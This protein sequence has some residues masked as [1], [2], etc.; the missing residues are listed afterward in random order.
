MSANSSYDLD[1]PYHETEIVFTA[2]SGY[3]QTSAEPEVSTAESLTPLR[4]DDIAAQQQVELL[5]E[6]LETNTVKRAATPL[7]AKLVRIKQLL[8]ETRQLN[9]ESEKYNTQAAVLLSA[10]GSLKAEL[11]SSEAERDTAFS[12]LINIKKLSEELNLQLAQHAASAEAQNK[13]SADNNSHSETLI[14]NLD[15]LVERAKIQQSDVN[16]KLDFFTEQAA[17][18]QNQA[19]EIDTK[20]IEISGL[21]SEASDLLS[22]LNLTNDSAQA[23]TNEL[24]GL[25]GEFRSAK[26]ECETLRDSLRE[27]KLEVFEERQA[28]QVLNAQSKSQMQQSEKL[29]GQQI[30]LLDLTQ[31]RH[32]ELR[33]ELESTIDTAKKYEN[34]L[35]LTEQKLK[36]ALAHQQRSEQQYADAQ[37]KLESNDKILKSA[38]KALT[39]TNG[40]NGKFNA[41][42][43]KFQHATEQSQNLIIRTHATLESV[44]N[45]NE[46]LERENKVLAQ[47]LNS[48][49]SHS[50]HKPNPQAEVSSAGHGNPFTFDGPSPNH[51]AS[52]GDNTAGSFRLMV[53]LA[54][55]VP[56]CFIAYS[57]V[58][59]ANASEPSATAN[60]QALA[61]HF[62]PLQ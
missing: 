22:Q 60:K 42:V 12:E 2:S 25:I 54:V 16:V 51:F 48:L 18:A 41:S 26:T 7:N 38:A 11:E 40:Q 39:E 30:T 15:E 21:A 3:P 6:K 45:R 55:L 47:R 20:Y 1:E 52:R 33:Q 57:F 23:R 5:K 27:L 53:F 34:R 8:V 37:S 17:K 29:N 10:L 62:L 44:I 35:Q 46:L 9:K 24:D 56:L 14:S 50:A 49:S 28:Q 32:E 36:D 59:S 31:S 19:L 58:N 61:E 4:S 13:R 43:S